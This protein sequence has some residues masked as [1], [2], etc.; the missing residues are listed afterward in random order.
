MVSHQE[1]EELQRA[2]VGVV[3]AVQ[4]QHDR[5]RIPEQ[6]A[7]F[8]VHPVVLQ[9]LHGALAKDRLEGLG[10]RLA[11]P[12]NDV[13][14][15]VEAA[16]AGPA[17]P[18]DDGEALL[19]GL[20]LQRLEQHGLAETA[21][22]LDQERASLPA[23]HPRDRLAQ[24]GKLADAADDA[25]RPALEVHLLEGRCTTVEDRQEVL[26]RAVASVGVLL[27][28]APAGLVQMVRHRGYQL[29]RGPRPGVE[30][31]VQEGW[32]GGGR[33][34][35]TPRQHQVEHHPQ[36]VEIGARVH[37]SAADAGVDLLG[38]DVGHRADHLAHHRE[39]R[40]RRVHHAEVHEHRR[41]VGAHHDVAGGDVAMHQPSFVDVGQRAGDLNQDD[42]GLLGPVGTCERLPRLH[43]G[44]EIVALDEI[45]GEPGPALVHPA[46]EDPTDVVVLQRGHGSELG[47]EA[48]ADLVA[49]HV[50]VKQLQGPDCAGLDVADAQHRSHAPA[51]QATEDDVRADVL[52]ARALGVG[53]GWSVAQG[54][55]VLRMRLEA[56]AATDVGPVRE[57][58]ED[59][60]LV[61]VEGGLFVVAD[62]M[63]GHAAGEVASA[64]AVETVREVLLDQADIDETVLAAS[65][66]DPDDAVRERLR[67]AMN[68]ASLA[69]RREV[70]V[71]PAYAGMGTTLVV[72]V[73]EQ[74][75]LHLAHVGD[76]RAYLVRDGRLMRLT[77][78]HTVVQQE[79][80]AGR[81]T[82][83]LARIVPHKNILT[84]SVGFHGPVDPD[85]S[86]RHL[87][88]GDLVLLCS[89]GCTDPLDDPE[90]L[91]LCAKTHPEDLPQV[92]VDESIRRGGEDNIT[93]VVVL[94]DA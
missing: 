12:A 61:D 25:V 40:A 88:D 57:T 82:P 37:P 32:D 59:A 84:K 20:L 56:Y 3:Q 76:S 11:E 6:V 87:E 36:G 9:A 94:V 66:D 55:I 34:R 92:L 67:Y 93:V 31:L 53:S 10:E 91:A 18:S 51:S 73:I 75:I 46:V 78:D 71:H 23:V 43:L 64:I 70:D 54:T 5:S 16:A 79:V 19:G 68:Q 22:P 21:G 60:L 7:H 80:D 85:T 48:I 33:K 28:Q 39:V 8:R 49:G 14:E 81:L 15:A 24:L 63:G 17:S 13:G 44:P 2:A 42:F 29:P 65:V 86:T 77:R 69:I 72:A 41:A 38:G 45:H 30:V 26:C 62:G 83:E 47:L 27:Q 90:I 52:L 74:D 35:P 58:N 1:G 4:Q 50:P 89:D